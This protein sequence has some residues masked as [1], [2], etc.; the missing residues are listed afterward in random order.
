MGPFAICKHFI[1]AK[2][3]D[4]QETIFHVDNMSTSVRLDDPITLD[5]CR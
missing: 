1:F 3:E 4:V 2:S 5:F